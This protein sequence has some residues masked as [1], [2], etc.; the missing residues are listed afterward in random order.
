MNNVFKLIAAAGLVAFSGAVAEAQPYYLAGNFEGWCNNCTEMTDNGA[1]G[2]GGSEQWAYQITGQTPDSWDTGGMKVTDGTWSNTWPGGNMNMHYDANGNATVY[3]YPGSFTDGYTP[4]ANRVG[5]ADLGTA[6]EIAGDFTSPTWGGTSGTSSDPNAQLTLEAGKT[7]V[8]TNIYIIPTAGTHNFKFRTSGT[9]S[10]A[11]VGTDFAGSGNAVVV[12]TSANEA[13]TFVLDLPNGRWQA[14]GPPP[15]CNVQFSVDMTLVQETD[16]GFSPT[17]VTISGD[18]VNGWGGTAC[19]NNP[20]AANPNV[21]YTPY[22]NLTVGTLVNYQYRYLSYGNT[23]YDAS[24]GISGVNRTLVVPNLASTNLPT[25]FWDDEQPDDI[26]N[27][28]TTVTFT[29]N[30]TNAVGTDNVVFD[31]TADSVYVNGD[32][33]GWPAWNPISLSSSVLANNPVGSDVFTFTYT[34][35]LGHSRAVTY[36]YSINGADDEA[37]YALNHF[38]YI[39]S[40]NGVYNFPMDTFG[41]QYV[42]PKVGGLTIGQHTNGVVPVTWLPYPNVAL[43]SSS[44]LT[45]W[46]V[47]ANT[48]AASATNW[49]ATNASTYFRLIQPALGQSLP[50]TP[51]PTVT[52][53]H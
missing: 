46:S 38:R 1:T 15:T 7:G 2:I 5:F 24:N 35:P 14:G 31:P 27:T 6:W 4:S 22:F 23:M 18:A 40:T 3:F 52:P 29:L 53:A 45:Q 50:G 10:D 37:G 42:E 39:R 19:T 21:Y 17:S 51:L 43:E 44:N 13:V 47:I 48:M 26:L 36:K 16:P 25:V 32:F 11:Q 41:N 12:T 8:Y 49:P 28:A 9:W 34:F 20:S 33:L 30:M